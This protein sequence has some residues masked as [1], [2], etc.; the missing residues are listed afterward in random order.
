MYLTLIRGIFTWVFPFNS[1]LF[2]LIHYILEGNI[3]DTT[4]LIYL[5]MY[6]FLLYF[7]S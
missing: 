7:Y 3:L 4:I 6:I 2:F 1:T 5:Y